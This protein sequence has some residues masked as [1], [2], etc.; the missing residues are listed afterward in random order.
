[1]SRAVVVVVGAV[2]VA[3]C[4]VVVVAAVAVALVVIVAARAWQGAL[5]FEDLRLHTGD[6]IHIAYAVDR[7]AY[8]IRQ[9]LIHFRVASTFSKDMEEEVQVRKVL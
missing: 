1:M 4:A 2:A 5:S 7:L 9:R 8:G 6:S 3:A